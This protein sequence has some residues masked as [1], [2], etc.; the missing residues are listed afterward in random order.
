MLLH[1]GTALNLTSAW[2]PKL[3][4]AGLYMTLTHI[5]KKY[6]FIW[7]NCSPLQ[8]VLFFANS[9]VSIL[10]FF[11]I[12]HIFIHTYIKVTVGLFSLLWHQTQPPPRGRVTWNPELFSPGHRGLTTHPIMV[13]LFFHPTPHF[14]NP[15]RNYF[16]CGGGEFVTKSHMTSD[17]ILVSKWKS[18]GWPP[19]WCFSPIQSCLINNYVLYCITGITWVSFYA[20]GNSI[21]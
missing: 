16:P 1:H 2:G 10:I 17:G 21:I 15:Q 14:S 9:T 20:L 5:K 8:F 19:L 11:K 12:L 7:T 4:P 6:G 18:Q 3:G 13:L